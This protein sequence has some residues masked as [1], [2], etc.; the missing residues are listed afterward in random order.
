MSGETVIN[1]TKPGERE[2]NKSKAQ[3]NNMQQNI[4]PELQWFILLS[5]VNARATKEK[6]KSIIWE[7]R[8]VR[9]DSDQFTKPGE[10]ESNK[11][12]AQLN[13]MQQNICPELQWF[14]LLSQVNARVT[15]TKRNSIICSKTYV[16]SY[17]DPFY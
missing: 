10:S 5:Q 7:K 9:R 15:K 16:R 8:Y 1:F 17:S 4:C 13:H 3:P 12:K 2:S 14:I 6:R 11:S